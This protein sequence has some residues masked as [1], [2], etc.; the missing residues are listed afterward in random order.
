MKKLLLALAFISTAQAATENLTIS[1]TVS[2]V[3]AFGSVTNGVFGYEVQSPTL[4]DTA[5]TGGTNG[6][7]LIFYNG[8]PTVSIGEITSF[9]TVPSGFT[10]TVNFTNVFTSNNAGTISYSSGN[11]SFTQ[12][13]GTN[14]TLTLRLRA[15]NANGSF[16]VGN[17]SAA[18][19][20]TCQ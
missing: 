1:G 17:Y 16:P 12:S 3:C 6:Q 8:T 18:T 9:S 15:L 4:L 14:D 5:S 13:G 20:I 10:D 11:A 19:T 7:V 2:S